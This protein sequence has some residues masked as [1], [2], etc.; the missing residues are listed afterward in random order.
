MAQVVKSR[1][2][3]QCRGHHRKLIK[4]CKNIPSIIARFDRNRTTLEERE[5][6]GYSQ[7]KVAVGEGGAL[8]IAIMLP[9]GEEIGNW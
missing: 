4:V 9:D 6:E 5:G 7:V 1:T 8:T 2:A 3:D